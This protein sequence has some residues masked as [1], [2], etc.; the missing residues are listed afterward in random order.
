MTVV[1]KSSCDSSQLDRLI[2]SLVPRAEQVTDVGAELSYILPS[3][4]TPSF[5]E[6]FDR[7]ETE[8]KALGIVSFGVSVTTMEEVFMKVGEGATDDP[9]NDRYIFNSI[10]YCSNS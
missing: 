10:N 6:L 7:L 4:A 8:R 5:P 9:L 1:K 2:K 3:S